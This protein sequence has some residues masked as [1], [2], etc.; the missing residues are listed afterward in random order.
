MTTTIDDGYREI[1][2]DQENDSFID[3]VEWH[4]PGQEVEGQLLEIDTIDINGRKALLYKFKDANDDFF[5]V[6]GTTDLDKKLKDIQWDQTVKIRYNDIIRTQKG[7]SMKQFRV[8]V[9]D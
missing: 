5:S 3:S 9:K 1:F 4:T 6:W 7:F 8:W 2:D